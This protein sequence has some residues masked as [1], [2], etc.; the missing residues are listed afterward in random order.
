ME[1]LLASELRILVHLP[2]KSTRPSSSP[3]CR[4]FAQSVW[5]MH[6]RNPQTPASPFRSGDSPLFRLTSGHLHSCSV[7]ISALAPPPRGE[8]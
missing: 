3:K 6:G 2:L 8:S 7:K 5:C 1:P 4:L